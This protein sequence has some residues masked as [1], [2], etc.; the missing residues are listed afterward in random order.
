MLAAISVLVIGTTL[1]SLHIAG[2]FCGLTL[3][4]VFLGPLSLGAGLGALLRIGLKTTSFQ[5][6]SWLP[7]LLI[8]AIPLIWALADGQNE[9]RFPE[10]SVSTARVIEASPA[11]IWDALMFYE[12]V[13]VDP[14]L[15]LRLGLPN[16]VSSSGPMSAPGDVR[17]CVYSKGELRK[18]I[19]A[20]SA[21]DHLA[22]EVIEQNIGFE[23]SVALVG[24]EFSL[25]SVG[26]R[27]TRLTLTTVYRPKLGARFVWSPIE[28]LAVQTL[29][30]HVMRGIAEQAQSA[31]QYAVLSRFFQ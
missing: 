7:Q 20:V 1:M 16:P 14:P 10:R 26:N 23:R 27:R 29:H 5:Q 24:G 15:L 30:R 11:E 19:T 21:P 17:T 31:P 25:L 6:R 3:L 8:S 28:R 4:V 2:L 18:R 13:G 12:D 9:V 22:F